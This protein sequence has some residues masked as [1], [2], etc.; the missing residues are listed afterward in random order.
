[1]TYASEIRSRSPPLRLPSG[2]PVPLPFRSP[3]AGR[4]SWWQILRNSRRR[5]VATPS[6]S[7]VWTW[8]HALCS[9]SGVGGAPRSSSATSR[10]QT[11]QG[12]CY[13]RCPCYLCTTFIFEM[14]VINA[15]IPPDLMHFHS[16]TDFNVRGTIS[17]VIDP[18]VSVGS[19]IISRT[20][21]RWLSSG[22]KTRPERKSSNTRAG[23][24]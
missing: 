11:R 16:L 3:R 23:T 9:R 19:P 13:W 21:K 20:E 6:S 4:S 14:P 10:T 15:D 12:R 2:R 22:R 1:M 24:Y 17:A 18:S 7:S 8:T 5:S